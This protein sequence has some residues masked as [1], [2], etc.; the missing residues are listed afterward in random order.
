MRTCFSYSVIS[1]FYRNVGLNI[2]EIGTTY[3]HMHE[4]IAINIG[5]MWMF[6]LFRREGRRYPL[7]ACCML[8]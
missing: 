4:S 2:A 5:A 8:A 6:F 7:A 1:T 3:S